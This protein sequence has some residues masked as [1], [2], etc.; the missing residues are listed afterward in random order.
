MTSAGAPLPFKERVQAKQM[1]RSG[2]KKHTHRTLI[3]IGTKAAVE[4]LPVL[5]KAMAI[6]SHHQLSSLAGHLPQPLTSDDRTSLL[7][8]PARQVQGAA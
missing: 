5:D 7:H 3:T 8:P 4:C 2:I 1:C 6:T